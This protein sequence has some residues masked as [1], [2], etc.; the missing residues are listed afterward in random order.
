[1]ETLLI[2]G[3]SNNPEVL[4]NPAAQTL[5]I[6]GFS[7]PQSTQ[8]FYTPLIHWLEDY[9][10]WLLTKKRL[11]LYDEPVTFKFKYTYFNSSSAKY[12]KDIALV[13]SD[14]S[15]NNIP[16]K[17]YWFFDAED[18]DLREEG[19]EISDMANLP[20]LFVEINR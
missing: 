16:L 3:T 5:Q 10:E 19:E 1:M 12:I 15:K 7:H 20:F 14:M 8:D 18:D 6:S 2:E 17:V 9:K 4:F 13:L 11:T